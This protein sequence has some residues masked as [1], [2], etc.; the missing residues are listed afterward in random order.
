VILNVA[1]HQLSSLIIYILPTTLSAVCRVTV[2]A[3][4]VE[5]TQIIV[6]SAVV[7]LTASH[8][9]FTA[10]LQEVCRVEFDV[11]VPIQTLPP[12]VSTI[13]AEKS[14]AAS[15]PDALFA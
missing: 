6:S 13:L 1:A 14:L 9:L 3:A 12:E 7:Q 5:V 10:Q 2:L 15:A 11:V 4:A 8:F